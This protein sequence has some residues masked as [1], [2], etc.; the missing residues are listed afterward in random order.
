MHSARLHFNDIPVNVSD[1]AQ[2]QRLSSHVD[3]AHGG[4]ISSR[5]YGAEPQAPLYLDKMQLASGARYRHKLPPW[6]C[7]FHVA[8]V[9]V[10]EH[11]AHFFFELEALFAAHGLC[12]E[13]GTAEHVCMR[14][15]RRWVLLKRRPKE[16]HEFK[17]V[18]S[19]HLRREEKGA[20]VPRGTDARHGRFTI[21][22]EFRKSH[23][24]TM[25]SVLRIAYLNPH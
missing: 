10:H 12:A 23:K 25:D 16:S 11:L 7:M 13:R 17:Q 6:K 24:V 2:S 20:R 9:R 18:R 19:F 22:G 14:N 8:I 5:T 15:R 21:P 4:V 1:I 3:T